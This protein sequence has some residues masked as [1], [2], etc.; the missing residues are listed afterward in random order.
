[1]FP[2]LEICDVIIFVYKI[3]LR[4]LLKPE[5]HF[6]SI[7]LIP[8]A[9]ENRIFWIDVL[10]K[11]NLTR[12]H[13]NLPRTNKNPLGTQLEPTETH[14]ELTRIMQESTKTNYYPCARS[15]TWFSGADMKYDTFLHDYSLIVAHLEKLIKVFSTF[16]IPP[17]VSKNKNSVAGVNKSIKKIT[18]WIEWVKWTPVSWPILTY[19]S[20]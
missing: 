17:S 13:Q 9:M 14:Q 19:D 4:A 3:S 20:H 8:T 1:M 16:L 7:I 15:L 11:V 5:D 2:E 6:F 10:N 18:C 12:T